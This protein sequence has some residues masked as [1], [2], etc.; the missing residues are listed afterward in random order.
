MMPIMLIALTLVSTPTDAG[1]GTPDD[2][3]KFVQ[4]FLTIRFTKGASPDAFIGAKITLLPGH[5]YLKK[6]YGLSEDV[7]RSQM[8]TVKKDAR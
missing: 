8:L 5:E 7:K 1:A 2:P 3:V 6:R 4:A